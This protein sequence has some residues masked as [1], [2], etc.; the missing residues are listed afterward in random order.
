MLK[1]LKPS[2]ILMKNIYSPPKDLIIGHLF[3]YNTVTRL[4]KTTLKNKK[5]V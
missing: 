4:R 1:I 5:K 3:K 2:A